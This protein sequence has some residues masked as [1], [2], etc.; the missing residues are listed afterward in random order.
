MFSNVVLNSS[1]KAVRQRFGTGIKNKTHLYG[2]ST[3]LEESVSCDPP[4]NHMC[5][6][7]KRN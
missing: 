5:V 7:K 6:D 4:G 1:C 3:T 2:G